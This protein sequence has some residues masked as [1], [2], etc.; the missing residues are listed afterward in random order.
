VLRYLSTVKSIDGSEWDV[1]E[2]QTEE[3][4]VAWLF[5]WDT[6]D[7]LTGKRRRVGLTGNYP[8]L[9]RKADGALFMW[10]LLEPL[11]RVLEKLREEQPALPRLDL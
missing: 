2:V 11:H 7:R 1:D 5:C 10:T 9:V 4:D 3:H 6:K 8:I